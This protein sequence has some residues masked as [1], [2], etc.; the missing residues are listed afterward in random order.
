MDRFFVEPTDVNLEEKYL[1][2]Y[3]DDVKHISKVLRYSI[4]DELEVC[5]GNNNEYI[6]EIKE[7]TKEAVRADIVKKVNINRESKVRVKLYQGLPKSTKMD[8]I[9]QKL[10]EAGV[11]EIILVNTKRSVVKV[12]K[13][14]SDKKF[15]RWERIVYEASKQ[16]KRGVIPALRGVLSFKEALKD[17]EENDFNISPYEAEKSLGIKEVLQTEEIRK[18][19]DGKEEVKI[20]IFI[21]PEG[22]FSEE[23][24]ELVKEEG[25]A[26]VSMG[27]RI[28]R[29]ETASI[30]ATSITL[31]ELGD[32]GGSF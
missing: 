10:T 22:G 9:L 12:D 30:V 7:M 24:N 15:D 6:C 3:G 28:F 1:D 16:S 11:A 25:I 19:V 20:G 31:Y 27:P 21:G 32:I 26:S 18:I 5:D 23:E 13:K 8:I 29:T 2:I 17:M 4:G 14:K